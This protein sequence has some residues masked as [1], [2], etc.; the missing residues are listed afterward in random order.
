MG[1]LEKTSVPTECLSIYEITLK[2]AS[3]CGLDSSLI[4]P[5][6]SDSMATGFAR[7]IYGLL[8]IS[9]AVKELDF[10]PLSLDEALRKE[11]MRP[12]G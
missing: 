1:R 10:T 9:K 6:S 3:T 4:R 12:L 5:V 11:L 8:D 7:P 2:V